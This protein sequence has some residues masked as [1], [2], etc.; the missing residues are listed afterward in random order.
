M[1]ALGEA[2]VKAL[3]RDPVGLAKQDPEVLGA[4]AGRR[5]W[6]ATGH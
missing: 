4:A 2:L 1:P 6:K 5:V 3:I